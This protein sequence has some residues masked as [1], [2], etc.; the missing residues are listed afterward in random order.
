MGIYIGDGTG[1]YVSML[2]VLT[3]IALHLAGIL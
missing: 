1:I 3:C 2:A